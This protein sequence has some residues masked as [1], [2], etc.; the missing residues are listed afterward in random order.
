MSRRI[1]FILFVLAVIF[2]LVAAL[3]WLTNH[4]FMVSPLV[5]A[6]MVCMAFGV[7]GYDSLKAFSYTIWILTAVCLGMFYP[8]YFMSVGDFELKKLIIPFVQLTM[9]GMGAHMSLDVFRG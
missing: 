8:K 1:A 7:R 5:V 6:A 4:I 2:I 3:L 9:F